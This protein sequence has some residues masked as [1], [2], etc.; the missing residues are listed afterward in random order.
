MSDSFFNGHL[1]FFKETGSLFFKINNPKDEDIKYKL[2]IF[3][4]EQPELR[5]GISYTAR[6]DH[7]LTEFQ[8]LLS[9]DGTDYPNLN[10]IR[11]QA[12]SLKQKKEFSL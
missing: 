4:Q 11:F 10:K 5:A 12:I 7:K 3:I 6:I 9:Y 8:V 2:K 1:K